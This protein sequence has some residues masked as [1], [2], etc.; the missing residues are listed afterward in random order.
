[1][2]ARAG[3]RMLLW[4]LAGC[5]YCLAVTTGYADGTGIDKVYHPYVHA[6]EREVE[7]RAS[8][9]DGNNAV[10]DDRQTWRLG[11]GQAL[12]EHW[13][14]ELYLHAEQ[15]NHQDLKLSKYEAEALWQATEQGE[16]PVDAG[17]LLDVE[18]NRDADITEVSGTLLLERDWG[19]W[20]GTANARFMYEFGSDIHNEPEPATALQLRYRYRM[21]F[22]PAVEYYNAQNIVGVGPV[23]LGDLR[24]GA[25]NRLHWEAGVIEGIGKQTPNSTLRLLLEYEF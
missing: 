7:L 5:L 3:R 24:L 20:T 1:M 11:Y 25:G 21:A 15:N 23:V 17:L 22:E 10:S 9:E 19:R 12:G 18:R 6:M 4:P 16:Y 2:T 14:G 13:F 8:I